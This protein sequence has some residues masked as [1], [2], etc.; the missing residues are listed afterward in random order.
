MNNKHSTYAHYQFKR[1]ILW[2]IPI[3]L[4]TDIYA[5][6]VLDI[7]RYTVNRGHSVKLVAMRSRNLPMKERLHNFD[8]FPLRRAPLV[9]NFFFAMLVFLTLPFY[10]ITYRPNFILTTPD[11]SFL[12]II[13]HIFI[14]KLSRIKLVLD[15]R[16]TPVET[17]GLRG[18]MRKFVFSMSITL[19]KQLL[20]GMTTITP[21]MR[22]EICSQYNLRNKRV[23]IWSVGVSKDLFDPEKNVSEGR[24]L[25]AA[26]G[27]SQKFVILYH[28]TLTA[29]RGLIE[30]VQA[31]KLLI[32]KH[33]DIVFL[34]LGTGSIV[35]A[36]R[37]IVQNQELENNV[38]IHDPVNQNEV[39]KFISACDTGIVPLPNNILWRAQ[40]PL[41][42][43][44]YLAMAKVV[45]VTDIPAHRSVIGKK[46][47]G[48]YI[49]SSK[50]EDIAESIDFLY[51][52][53]TNLQKWG[54]LGRILVQN[55]YTWEKAAEDLEH[56]L[57]SV[58]NKTY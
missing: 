40:C 47:C 20:D 21:M 51:K 7:L 14:S 55:E 58:E 30:V 54:K 18:A 4:D 38:L 43:L 32:P 19:A 46:E 23:G 16:S 28:G 48:K 27:L 25:K 42:L 41:K 22:R 6:S 15:I 5:K 57:L 31:I 29:T 13:P 53:R 26:L 10:I 34:L 17:I 33:P 12:S 50:P 39:P 36:L 35:S 8:A 45:L 9:S 24:E 52:R 1:R 44:E 37:R 3:V 11:L 49:L 2:I 56:Y